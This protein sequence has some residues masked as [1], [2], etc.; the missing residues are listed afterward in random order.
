M[1]ILASCLMSM[2][3]SV[4]RYIYCQYWNPYWCAMNCINLHQTVTKAQS[5]TCLWKHGV[6]RNMEATKCRSWWC[7]YME[8]CTSTIFEQTHL[9]PS[10]PKQS[11]LGPKDATVGFHQAD[12]FWWEV[13]KLTHECL[14]KEN[15]YNSSEFCPDLN[16]LKST[17]EK[18]MEKCVESLL[19]V[20]L[21]V[22]AFPNRY[23]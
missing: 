9:T 1:W 3:G 22:T 23:N 21:T 12:K 5:K 18:E 19:D 11:H 6:W 13:V 8:Q 2:L 16:E 14:L 7:I 17:I 4:N 15:C 20:V 10:I